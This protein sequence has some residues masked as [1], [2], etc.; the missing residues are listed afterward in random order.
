MTFTI[1][2]VAEC[3]PMMNA[4]QLAE[5]AEDIRERGLLYPVTVLGDVLLDGR[6]R[7]AA[8]EIADVELLTEEYAGDD[9]IGFILATNKR[10]ELT[11]SQRSMVAAKIANLGEGRPRITA[12]NEAVI[13][14]DGAARAMRVSRSSVQRAVE[15]L[16]SPDFA[17]AV[18]NGV[19][20]LGA[21]ARLLKRNLASEKLKLYTLPTDA[22][23]PFGVIVADPPWT[24]D[25]RDNDG[26]HRAANPYPSMTIDEIK[27]IQ[28]PA[29]DDAIL[30]L[31]TTNA[32][33][34]HSFDVCR[35]W[36]FDPKTV[37][38]WVKT[39][40]GLGDWLR[41]QTEHCIFAVRG[42]PTVTLTN[43]TTALVAAAA[44]HSAKPDEF[45]ELVE[46]LCPDGRRLELFARRRRDGWFC[47]GSD[48][49]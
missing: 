24:Y 19:M 17:D 25:A 12:S 40:I 13:S 26:T 16:G 44:N 34:E 14:Q 23:G 47:S 30:W 27:A 8:C 3:F 42:K 28:I 21:A 15:V 18:W 36:G 35:S 32:H 38:T 39:R 48:L 43:Q 1:H 41:G 10:R 45:Y 5:L 33:I 37:L 7:M 20:S 29:D 4:E 46:S 31:W 11:T 2:P 9:P 49:T 22:D 6:N